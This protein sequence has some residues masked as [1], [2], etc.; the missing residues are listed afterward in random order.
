MGRAFEYRR[1]AKERRWATMSRVFPK[2]SK[3]ITFAAKSGGADPE[4]NAPLRM[5][6][7]NAKNANMPKDNIEAAI[8]RATDQDQSGLD[9]IRYE[10]Y[11]PHG[12]AI[13]V[14]TT[15]DNP[16]R[17]VANLRTIFGRAGGSLG[18]SNSVAFQFSH[19]GVFRIPAAGQDL[20]ELQLQLID[21]GLE[22]LMEEETE[23]GGAELVILT[24]FEAFGQMQKGLEGLGIEILKAEIQWFPN[25]TTELTE[26]QQADIDKLVDKLQDDD[27]VQDVYT[28]LAP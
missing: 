15:T 23:D 13:I 9:N 7:Q 25:V 3:A 11:G 2:L 24:P 28:S 16:N 8:R 21:Y 20:D 19:L 17:T 27:D 1:A 26:A 18:V 22:E 14:E 12:I 6:I 10:G 4:L 5:A